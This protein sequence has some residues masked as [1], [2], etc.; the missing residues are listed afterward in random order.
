MQE[1]HLPTLLLLLLPI[2]A[3]VAVDFLPPAEAEVVVVDRLQAAEVQ[4]VQMAAH[5]AV[6]QEEQ[7][8]NF[9]FACR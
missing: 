8:V 7:D 3:T 6:A 1:I 2:E 5:A 4:V 9:I